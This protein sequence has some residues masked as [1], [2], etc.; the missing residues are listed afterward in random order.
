[1]SYSLTLERLSGKVAV[2]TGASAGIGKATVELLVKQGLIVAGIAR[3]VTRIEEHAQ[4]LNGEKGTLHPYQ[5]DLTQQDQIISTFEKIA[6]ELGSIHVLINNAGMLFPS[7]I[8]D[9]DIEKWKPVLDTNV[10]AVA[11]CIRQAVADM[12]KH[13][14]KGHIINMNSFAGHQVIDHPLLSLYPASKHA[15]TALT[16][17]VRLEINR[18]KLPI[19]ITSLSPGAVETEFVDAAFGPQPKADSNRKVM[20]SEDIADAILYILATPDHVNVKELIVVP[21]GESF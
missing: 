3:R 8:I 17:T 21:Q 2:V 5:C 20:Q 19:K 15:L 12:K 13:N 4:K 1:M 6:S 11:I 18:E 9:G 10:L 16:E 7:N 14:T